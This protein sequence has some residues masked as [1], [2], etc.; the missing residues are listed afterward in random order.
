MPEEDKKQ[1]FTMDDALMPR[2]AE[3]A[4]RAD[5]RTRVQQTVASGRV[6][7]PL[8]L[9]DTLRELRELVMDNAHRIP[10]ARAIINQLGAGEA[11]LVEDMARPEDPK[12][13]AL[14]LDKPEPVEAELGTGNGR[15]RRRNRSAA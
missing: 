9:L 15:G 12:Q 5:F 1:N 2:E 3:K 7:T 4:R 8:N 13:E 11:L 14:S 10:K 6:L